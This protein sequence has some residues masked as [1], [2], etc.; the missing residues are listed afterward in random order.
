MSSRS[1]SRP[2]SVDLEIHE[3][4]GHLK[5]S[6]VKE[7]WHDGFD[8]CHGNPSSTRAA[9]AADSGCV[10]HLAVCRDFSRL[11]LT[12]APNGGLHG[13]PNGRRSSVRILVCAPDAVVGTP[14]IGP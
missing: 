7:H 2:E 8:S 11:R 10:E 5:R 12:D 14:M 13:G 1:A 6:A 4:S 9:V 3:F